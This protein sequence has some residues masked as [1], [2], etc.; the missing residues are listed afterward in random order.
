[1]LPRVCWRPR[2]FWYTD[3]VI[4][5]SETKTS[6]RVPELMHK[7]IAG[8]TASFEQLYEA[9][10]TPVYRYLLV[11]SKEKALAEDLTQAVFL[12]AF[13]HQSALT[14]EGAKPLAYLYTVARN[15]L[16]DHWKKK[17]EVHQ[18]DAAETFEK[19]PDDKR[20]PDAL[21]EH[22]DLARELVEGL[23][24]LTEEQREVVSLKYL[25]D[26]S[27]SE[28]AA[29]IGK[30]E[31]AVRQLQCRGLKALRTVMRS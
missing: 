1:M 26:Y 13:E 25:H 9:Y 6:K 20:T 12:K 18:S 30:S 17:K 16:I 22:N 24:M 29:R 14:G 11:R 21:A 19:K 8:D 4:L 27:V 15:S 5:M 10:M 3:I 23:A 28:I 2:H 7:A 31:E